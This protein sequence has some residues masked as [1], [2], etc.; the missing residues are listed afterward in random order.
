MERRGPAAGD[1]ERSQRRSGS[2]HAHERRDGGRPGGRERRRGGTAGR[3]LRVRPPPSWGCGQADPV[4]VLGYAPAAHGKPDDPAPP[5][6]RRVTRAAATIAPA[7]T[8]GRRCRSGSSRSSESIPPSTTTAGRRSIPSTSPG[9]RSTPGSSST[10]RQLQLDAPI[11]SILSS[12]APIH[13][14]FLSSLDENDVQGY[15]GIPVNSNGLMPDFLYNVGAAGGVFLPPGRYYVSVD[16]GRDFFTG[17]SL[18]RPYR[19]RSW[20]NDVRPPNIYADHE[21]ALGGPSDHRRA[22]ERRPLGSRPVLDAPPLRGPA[23]RRDCVRLGHGHRRVP[24]PAR[25]ERAPA[26]AGVHAYLRLGLSGD[27][28]HPDRRR[29][30]DAE[31]QVP[32]GPHGSRSAPDDRVGAARTRTHASLRAQSCRS[33]R[34]RTPRSPRSGSSTEDARSPAPGATSRGSTRSRGGRPARGAES[35]R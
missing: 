3:Q 7:C 33:S 14:W 2:V 4:R 21:A 12:N 9:R 11:T 30:P 32:R 13:P 31:L 17:R 35:T 8:A 15:S 20:V 10:V 24:D 29:E 6:F 5:A 19:L 25:G 26:G 1:V 22:R 23:G 16:S 27:E 34:A 18:A 28:E